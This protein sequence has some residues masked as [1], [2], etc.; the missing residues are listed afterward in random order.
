MEV[1]AET[2]KSLGV[3]RENLK[4]AISSIFDSPGWHLRAGGKPDGILRGALEYRLDLVDAIAAFSQST[5]AL[6]AEICAF[7]PLLYQKQKLASTE[8]VTPPLPSLSTLNL[9]D[10]ILKELHLE[11]LKHLG[12]SHFLCGAL[13][14]NNLLLSQKST[15]S[16][17]SSADLVAKIS[18]VMDLME[19]FSEQ[20]FCELQRSQTDSV[21]RL[22][23]EFAASTE[24]ALSSCRTG[25]SSGFEHA[26]HKCEEATHAFLDAVGSVTVRA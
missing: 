23:G 9:A 21:R 14:F 12:Q 13:A 5:L 17:F 11:F 15:L 4:N 24:V 1:L 18:G 3:V 10:K 6:E 20:D 22:I 7:R 8:D 16:R 25:G 19:E 2:P 26:L